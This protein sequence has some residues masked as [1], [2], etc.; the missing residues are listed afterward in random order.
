[1]MMVGKMTGTIVTL[2]ENVF[3]QGKKLS[4]NLEALGPLYLKTLH[5]IPAIKMEYLELPV[6]GTKQY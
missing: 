2:K 4:R 1:M 5:V 3:A 6:R